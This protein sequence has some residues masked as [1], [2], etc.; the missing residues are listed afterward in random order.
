METLTSKIDEIKNQINRTTISLL[1]SIN[2]VGTSNLGKCLSL[3]I[4]GDVPEGM[5]P[6]QVVIVQPN[7]DVEGWVGKGKIALNVYSYGT[8]PIDKIPLCDKA[9]NQLKEIYLKYTGK[10]YPGRF[11]RQNDVNQMFFGSIL[12]IVKTK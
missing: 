5:K 3:D 1:G 11:Y 9:I 6:A 4:N 10:E 8:A 2:N 7:S 12:E